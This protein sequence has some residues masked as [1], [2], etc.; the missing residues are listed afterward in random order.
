MTLKYAGGS[1]ARKTTYSLAAGAKKT[2]KLNLTAAAKRAFKRKASVLV[3]VKITT[4]GG[5]T[6][7]KTLRLK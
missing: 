6:V 2:L 4:E 5:K 3:Q 7:S 1:L